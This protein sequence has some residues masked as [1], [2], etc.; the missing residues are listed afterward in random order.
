[1]HVHVHVRMS[2]CVCARVRVRA[3]VVSRPS[4]AYGVAVDSHAQY[5]YDVGEVCTVHAHAH[6]HA[7]VQYVYDVGEVCM[8]PTPTPTRNHAR[9]TLWTPRVDTS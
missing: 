9:Q 2:G 7:H 6:A 5:V 1:M 3:C 4:V 8:A